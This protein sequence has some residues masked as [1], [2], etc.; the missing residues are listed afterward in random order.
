MEEV[1][2]DIP[3]YQGL[4]QI[5]NLGRVKSNY[6]N[7]ILK[8]TLNK[9]TQYY[10][11]TL[12][13]N[14][15][16]KYHRINRLVG[17]TFISNPDNLPC[18]DHINRIRSDNSLSNLRWCSYSDNCINRTPKSGFQNII[19]ENRNS[20]ITYRI[21]ITRNNNIICRKRFKT[22]D[23]AIKYRDEI[24]TNLTDD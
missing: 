22:I 11:I 5:S 15:E 9:D 10:G 14:T 6:S 1:W 20:N 3:D 4:Y 21:S 23:E 2:K 19:I 16:K 7:R 24:L 13:K 17:I 18:I 8:P 12:S